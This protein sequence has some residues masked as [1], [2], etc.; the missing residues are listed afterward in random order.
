MKLMD[1][2][3]MW[4]CYRKTPTPELREKLIIEYAQLVKL[5]AGRLS[6][7]LGHN[8]EFDDLVSYGI[9]GLIDAIDKF[10]TD[11]NVKFETYASLRIRGAIL[12]QIRKMDWIPRTVR[13]RQ[14]KIDDA[15][16]SVEMR[17]GKNASDEEL[18]A[19]LKISEE[20]LCSWQSQLKVTNIVSLDEFQEAGPEP[21]MDA[22]HNSHFA[23]PEDVISKDELKQMLL[24]SLDSLT[25]KER[26]VIELYYYDDLTLKEIS[27]VLSVSESRVSQLHTKALIKMKKV[28]GLYMGILT[29]S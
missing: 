11:K 13:Q 27:Q 4:D 29:E 12:D 16:K 1:K 20:E 6:M 23:Q 14:R 9:F 26:R 10:D 7:Y 17:T 24:K 3:K 28:M 19:E 25:E 22:T 21:V 5:V 15:I 18:A 2:E 8:V